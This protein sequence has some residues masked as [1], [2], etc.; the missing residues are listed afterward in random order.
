MR[1]RYAR[2]IFRVFVKKARASQND[3]CH[4]FTHASP[5][6]SSPLTCCHAHS[7][8]MNWSCDSASILSSASNRRSLRSRSRLLQKKLQIRTRTLAETFSCKRTCV[9]KTTSH[10]CVCVCVCVCCVCL[11]VAAPCYFQLGTNLRTVV[12]VRGYGCL[13]KEHNATQYTGEKTMY[14]LGMTRSWS[15]CNPWPRQKYEKE[16]TYSLIV[17]YVLWGEIG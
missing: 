17:V 11:C 4:P 6:C 16:D 13:Y 15:C 14:S 2:I 1:E 3:A 10:T 9:G 12:A 8:L 7:C 5:A